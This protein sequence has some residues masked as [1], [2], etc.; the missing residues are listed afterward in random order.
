[1]LCWYRPGDEQGNGSLI[2]KGGHHMMKMNGPWQLKFTAG[3]WGQ[4]QC[5]YNARPASDS[6]RPA[7]IGEW[8]HFA[9]VAGSGENRLFY[10]GEEAHRL[11]HKGGLGQTGFPWRIGGNAEIPLG[12]I[13]DGVL[14]EVMIFAGSLT[15]EDIRSLMNNGKTGLPE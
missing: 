12:R 11:P 8:A 9:G 5:Y 7:W 14:D 10:N 6:R 13:P 15:G 3:G 2:T 4:G 1:M